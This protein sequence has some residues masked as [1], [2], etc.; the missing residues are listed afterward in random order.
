M[1]RWAIFAPK[2]CFEGVALF[3]SSCI[4]VFVIT[5]SYASRACCGATGL[6]DVHHEKAMA[7]R[8]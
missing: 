7:R 4:F 8:D 3:L 1:L 5:C 2:F 6:V